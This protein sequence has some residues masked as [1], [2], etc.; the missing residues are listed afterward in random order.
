[1]E[2]LMDGSH[3]DILVR[4]I[5][6]SGTRRRLV[7]LLA[8]LPL[9]GVLPTLGE[10]EAAAQQRP[11]DRLQQRTPQRNRKQRNNNQNNN[12]NNNQNNNGGGGGNTPPTDPGPSGCDC[13]CMNDCQHQVRDCGNDSVD[14]CQLR[15]EPG[16]DNTI[17]ECFECFTSHVNECFQSLSSCVDACQSG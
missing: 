16:S 4:T 7:S 2:V 12:N 13:E 14:Q 1:M 17:E 9:G 3:F 15:C 8:A 10:E 11:I 5:A 6:H